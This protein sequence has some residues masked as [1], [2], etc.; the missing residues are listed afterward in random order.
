VVEG[1]FSTLRDRTAP[2]C[3]RRNDPTSQLRAALLGSLQGA[4]FGTYGCTLLSSSTASL[5]TADW[6]FRQFVF[7]TL[8]AS[9]MGIPGYGGQFLAGMLA[10]KR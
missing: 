7:C 4:I 6:Y 3:K 5:F 10:Q 1:V 8:G 2:D 9:L